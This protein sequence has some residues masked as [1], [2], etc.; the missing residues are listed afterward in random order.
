MT[1]VPQHNSTLKASTDKP[2]RRTKGLGRTELKRKPGE[3]GRRE[4]SSLKRGK[5]FA[6]SSAQQNKVRLTLCIVC[7]RDSYSVPIDPAHVAARSCGGCA[8]PDCVVPLCRSCHDGFDGGR[9]SILENLVGRYTVEIQ[10]ALGHYEGDVI[11][12]LQRLTNQRYEPVR[13]RTQ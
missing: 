10:H 13:E 1:R 4:A 12:L 3:G 9:L 11:G 6:A 2:L 7:G 5:A 8:E